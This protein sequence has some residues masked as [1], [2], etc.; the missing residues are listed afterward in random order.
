MP[1][2]RQRFTIVYAP[3]TKQHLQTIEA[4][5][6]RLIRDTISEQLAFEPT[7]ETR[8][9]KPL[10]RPVVFMATWELRFGPHNRFRAYYDVDLEQAI[11]AILAIGRKHGNRVVVGGEEIRL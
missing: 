10:K 5:Y 4:K 11:V 7:I 1:D 6:Y 8:N 9:R 2:E 3:I